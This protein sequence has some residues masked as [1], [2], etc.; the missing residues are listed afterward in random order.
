MS[1]FEV[2]VVVVRR[3]LLLFV[4]GG[5]VAVVVCLGADQAID[6]LY[7]ENVTPEAEPVKPLLNMQKM[8]VRFLIM[9]SLGLEQN[10]I[11]AIG[12][13][14]SMGDVYISIYIYIYI[15]RRHRL[16]EGPHFIRLSNLYSRAQMLFRGQPHS[17]NHRIN[18]D[19]GVIEF[20][21]ILMMPIA[22]GCL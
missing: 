16:N 9:G 17:R 13:R 18:M 4:G 14:R 5:G 12:S 3:L 21:W 10:P 15:N 11:L 22:I 20:I 1:Y 19:L 8:F 2:F 6:R 7:N